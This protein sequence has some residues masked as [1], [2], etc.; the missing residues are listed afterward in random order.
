MS[1]SF[2]ALLGFRSFVSVRVGIY[3]L[4]VQK[5]SNGLIIKGKVRET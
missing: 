4:C 5:L 2:Q 1:T 3:F